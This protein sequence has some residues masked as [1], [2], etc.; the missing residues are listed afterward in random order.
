MKLPV[1]VAGWQMDLFRGKAQ[2][3]AVALQNLRLGG[4]V[5]RIPTVGVLN[6][7]NRTGRRRQ[8]IVFTR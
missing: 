5:Q 4:E 1:L 7:P 3:A 2:G 6:P 8:V